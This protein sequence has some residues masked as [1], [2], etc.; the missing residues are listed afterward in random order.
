MDILLHPR[1]PPLVL[2]L[3]S[4]ENV[5][6]FRA[7]ESEVEQEL[8]GMLRLAATENLSVWYPPSHR[9]RDYGGDKGLLHRELNQPPR[10]AR[11]TK[12]LPRFL[13]LQTRLQRHRIPRRWIKRRSLPPLPC[14]QAK[15][16]PKL[17]FRFR[18][19]C[20]LRSRLTRGHILPL[21]VQ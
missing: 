4:V 9:R 21:G 1:L 6:L 15:N 18:T 8:R 11:S 7:E 17:T 16:Q 14:P 12:L 5:S 3:P 10:H 13:I 20:L 19:R 2:S